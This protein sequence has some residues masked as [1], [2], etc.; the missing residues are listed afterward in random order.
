MVRSSLKLLSK[1]T[2]VYGVSGTVSKFILFLTIPIVTR[3]LTKDQYGMVDAVLSFTTALSGF[4]ILGQD[5]SIARY[6]Y[7]R[8]MNAD[9]R[10]T[11]AT[12]GFYIQIVLMLLFLL[13]LLF[14]RD[15]I[16][17]LIYAKQKSIYRY[18]EICI[19]SLPGSIFILFSLNLLK[20]TFKKYHFVFLSLGNIALNTA[21]TLYF[22]LQLKM[23]IWGVI[24]PYVISLNIF[25]LI[26]VG[27]CRDYLDF[28]RVFNNAAL[29]RNMIWYGI[30]FTVVMIATMLTPTLDRLFLIR[31]SS[32]SDIGI[33]SISGKIASMITLLTS[34]FAV[35]FGPYAFS[36]W[37]KDE[38]PRIFS[39]IFKVYLFVLSFAGIVILNLGSILITV[40]ASD[41]YA[42]SILFLPPL[43]LAQ[44]IRGF[45]EF[46]LIGVYWSKKTYYNIVIFGLTIVSLFF[47]N[48][49]LVPRYFLYGAAVSFLLSNIIMNSVAFYISNK[50][51]KIKIELAKLVSLFVVI[52]LIFSM[53]YFQ[54]YLP[55][56]L[57]VMIKV[58]TTVIYPVL[59]F[60]CI[61]NEIE[62]KKILS[63]IKR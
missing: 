12:I 62:R 16:A 22:V 54:R 44:I 40:F 21:L 48:L 35:A 18:W 59:F 14:G 31:Y 58:F 8:N 13:A 3:V 6:F 57:M 5:S 38:A 26:G 49:L 10:K 50:Y 36:M 32:L 63:Y 2:I 33:Y 19:L 11:V 53:T 42:Q 34:S 55:G 60:F 27:M 56:N 46:S 17:S 47:M 25:G 15:Q 29:I 52:I 41:K 23:G 20:W 4:V 39:Q 28:R 24:I 61:F 51:Y 37:Q 7:D 45:Q 30:P 1:D 9:R 43:L